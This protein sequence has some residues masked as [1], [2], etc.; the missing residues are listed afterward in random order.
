[1]ARWTTCGSGGCVAP[2][3]ADAAGASSTW[4][5]PP[6]VTKPLFPASSAGIWRL[7]PLKSSAASSP[8]STHGSSELSAGVVVTSTG[9]PT[10]DT[11]SWSRLPP[12]CSQPP[13]GLSP[14][15]SRSPNGANVARST[16]WQYSRT[17]GSPSSTRSRPRSR[18]SRR[19]SA[20]MTP[21]FVWGR[22]SF[23][24]GLVGSQWR[25]LECSS[26]R[27]SPRVDEQSP[28]TQRH[29]HRS[30]HWAAESCARASGT[31]RVK[32]SVGSG[33]FQASMGELKSGPV[34]VPSGFE[35]ARLCRPLAT[36]RRRVG[37]RRKAH[38]YQSAD[39]WVTDWRH[40]RGP[41]C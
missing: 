30:I 41:R 36:D 14:R 34:G 23:A 37:G 28:D 39:A 21:R 25:L 13:A 26:S 5:L 31:R 4:R 20:G 9:W 18:A 3:A 16:S 33:S 24:K 40:W 19:R 38:G 17:G 6:V 2:C 1:M 15:K 8:C 29:S 10:H 11:L 32:R 35:R 27:I 22:A 7:S 12:A